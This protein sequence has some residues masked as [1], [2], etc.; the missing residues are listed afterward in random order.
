VRAAQ[1][2]ALRVRPAKQ[3]TIDFDNAGFGPRYFFA[4]YFCDMSKSALLCPDA[5]CRPTR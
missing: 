5:F 2:L 1:V 4:R 3:A